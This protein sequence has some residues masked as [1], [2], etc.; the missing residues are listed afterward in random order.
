[1]CK[2]NLGKVLWNG[3][4]IPYHTI[5]H[6]AENPE[7]IINKSG[8]RENSIKKLLLIIKWTQK[9]KMLAKPPEIN[10][11]RFLFCFFSHICQIAGNEFVIFFSFPNFWTKVVILSFMKFC[12]ARTF[13]VE[14]HLDDVLEVLL[15]FWFTEKLGWLNDKWRRYLNFRF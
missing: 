5:L 15:V 14:L 8:K 12:R 1:M 13:L 9:R 2:L 6:K 3:L 11:S 4:Y 7:S 10:G